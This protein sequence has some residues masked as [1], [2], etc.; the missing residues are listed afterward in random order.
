MTEPWKLT[1]YSGRPVGA[2][3]A[4]VA[5]AAVKKFWEY[6]DLYKVIQGGSSSYFLF[7][8]P[9]KDFIDIEA[10]LGEK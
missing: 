5:N 3:T 9:K 6:L 7:K 10:S 4:D 2:V 8:I 1:E